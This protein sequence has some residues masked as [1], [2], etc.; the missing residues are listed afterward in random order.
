MK[1]PD[2]QETT[3]VGSPGNVLEVQG[4]EKRFGRE[5]AVHGV[6]L[7]LARSE[8]ISLLGPSG[9]G[10]TTTLRCL[11]G[12]Y[13]PD[14]GRITI[15]GRLVAGPGVFVPPED[16]QIAMVFQNYV[17]WPHMTAFQNIAYGLRLRHVPRPEIRQRVEEMLGLLGLTG[18][19]ERYPHQLSGGQQQRV[20]VARSLVVRPQ[21]LLLDEPFSN[22]DAKLRVQMREEMRDLLQRLGISAVYVTHDQEE[23]M[24]ISDRILLMDSGRLIEEGPPYEL[25]ERPRH[26]FTARFFGIAN[27]V[28][29]ALARRDGRLWFRV[30]GLDAEVRLPAHL[31]GADG[32]RGLLGLRETAFEVRPGAPAAEGWFAGTIR[33]RFY[34]GGAVELDV[35]YAGDRV[36]RCSVDDHSA[37][38]WPDEVS[39]RIVTD[40]AILLPAPEAAVR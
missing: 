20:S 24:T 1:T 30:D 27:M 14:A 15:G 2:P 19:G 4:L 33:S 16:R 31:D 32:M 18:L 17:L 9:C 39:V 28:P 22:L 25:F 6:N 38:S 5:A 26:E 29:G 36:M 23:A 12:F 13:R 34:V 21:L 11:A 10:K 3:G 8:V 7:H 37:M 35:R 40:R